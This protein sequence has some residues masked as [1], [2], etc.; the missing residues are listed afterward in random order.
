MKNLL[1]S[2]FVWCAGSSKEALEKCPEER[3]I[4]IGYGVL[5]LVPATFAVLAVSYAIFTVVDN[6]YLSVGLGIMSGMTVFWFD[7]FT[8][9]TLQKSRGIGNVFRFLGRLV[10]ALPISLMIAH[11]LVLSIFHESIEA[12]IY[13]NETN[14]IRDMEPPSDY[15]ARV[16]ALHRL[17]ENNTHVQILTWFLIIFFVFIDV[18][19]FSF[20]VMTGRGTYDETLDQF[21]TNSGMLRAFYERNIREYLGGNEKDKSKKVL[22]L[23]VIGLMIGKK[24]KENTRALLILITTFML[25][26]IISVLLVAKIQVAIAIIIFCLIFATFL[27]YFLLMYRVRKGFYG[28]NEHESREIVEFILSHENPSDFTGGG[29]MKPLFPREDSYEPLLENIGDEVKI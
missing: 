19:P 6:I 29:R 16:E 10:L 8:L 27:N 4:H 14:V 18:L 13:A 3:T 9:S 25:Y 26:C 1:S 21:P 11:S 5:V 15:L 20:K 17:Y 24:S 22:E 2:F 28:S 7:R 23:T 12:E